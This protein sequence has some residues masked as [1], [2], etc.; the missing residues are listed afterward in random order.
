ESFT[1]ICRDCPTEDVMLRLAT[2][3]KLNISWAS[4]NSESSAVIS[5][6]IRNRPVT[7]YIPFESPQRIAKIAAG[8]ASLMAQVDDTNSINICDLEDYK[9]VDEHISLL[10]NEAI[11]LWK[12]FLLTYHNDSRIPN[13]HFALG[14]LFTAQNNLPNA[15]AE[16]KLI[17]SRFSNTS[18][19]PNALLHSSIIKSQILDYA[20]VSQDLNQLIEQYPDS[21]I[22][23]QACLNLAET[24]FKTKDY[25]QASKR[26]QKV[27]Y[28]SVN[29]DYQINAA[30]GAANSLYEQKDYE[31][32]EQWFYNYFKIVKNKD[33][34]E[35]YLANYIFGQTSLALNKNQQACDS[36]KLALHYNNSKDQYLTTL[37]ALIDSYIQKK[38]F[39]NAIKQVEQI[40]L[41][42]FSPVQYT[43]ILLIQSKVFRSIGLTEKSLFLLA[44]KAEYISDPQL[45]SEVM[46]EMSLCYVSQGN[47][48]KAEE[49]LSKIIT[50]VEPGDYA[51]QIKLELAQV[52][53]DQNKPDQ[54]ILI[55][56]KI[57]DA[58]TNK[59]TREKASKLA[60]EAYKYKDDYDSAA[61]VLLK[62]LNYIPAEQ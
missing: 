52:L 60:S 5:S 1:V 43:K 14:K 2:N 8:C 10:N 19:A 6:A 35:Y 54:T 47:L 48:N 27:Y 62:D 33:T 44:D 16:F 28:M 22:T 18:F 34:Q 11:S 53:F 38:D 36:F 37:L 20:G 29:R 50:I 59:Q 39:V 46:L 51:D 13:A 23:D 32:A 25:T 15:I 31:N 40:P 3:A 49:I 21:L 12:A 57:M 24:N 58:N 4:S 17:A 41:E 42:K 55:C 26:Y 30:L 45:K 7:I 61:A 56:S 9:S